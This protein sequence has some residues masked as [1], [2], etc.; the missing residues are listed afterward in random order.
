MNFISKL[1]ILCHQLSILFG[2]LLNSLLIFVNFRFEKFILIFDHTDLF[3]ILTLLFLVGLYLL[4]QFFD[5]LLL[6]IFSQLILL[7]LYLVSLLVSFKFINNTFQKA[8]L[9]SHFLTLF[10]S[11]NFFFP[12]LFLLFPQLFNNFIVLLLLYFNFIEELLLLLFK[13]DNNSFL[14]T[15]LLTEIA[16]LLFVFLI[17]FL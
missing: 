9:Y 7:H 14:L 11:F 15:Y 13:I 2:N 4:L 6:C 1:S 12:H 16:D 10:L 5:Q 3:L 17:L 8:H